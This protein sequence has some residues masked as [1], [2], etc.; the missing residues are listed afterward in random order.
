MFK[1]LKL[2]FD[3]DNYATITPK[4]SYILDVDNEHVVIGNPDYDYQETVHSSDDMQDL[5][6]EANNHYNQMAQH[7]FEE[8]KKQGL[9]KI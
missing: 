3:D 9:I 2:E 4:F 8:F 1:P 5:I 7:F 6:I